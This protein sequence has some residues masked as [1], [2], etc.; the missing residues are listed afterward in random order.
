MTGPDDARRDLDLLRAMLEGGDGSELPRNV[1][2]HMNNCPALETSDLLMQYFNSSSNPY[3]Q[4][5]AL[6]GLMRLESFDR[7]GYICSMLNTNIYSS[8]RIALCE[9]LTMLSDDRVIPTL[10]AVLLGD[11]DSDVRF[12]ASRL[13]GNIGDIS[14]IHALGY[15]ADHDIGSDYEGR[16]IA[17]EARKA[18]EQIRARLGQHRDDVQ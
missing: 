4:C 3:L 1:I 8:W 17:D 14:A 18:I 15:A 13:L 2:E 10:C 16:P 9:D 7:V 11:N 12:I 6:Y 5:R